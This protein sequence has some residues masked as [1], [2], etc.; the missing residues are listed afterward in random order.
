MKTYITLD[1][2]KQIASTKNVTLLT[3]LVVPLN[4][5][6]ER[7]EINTKLRV[8]HF[9]AQVLHESGSFI[10]FRELASGTA[11]EGRKDLG[12]VNPGD[13]VKYKGRGVIQITGRANYA[14]LSKDLGV[15]FVNQPLLLENHQWGVI[16]AG[17]FW[18]K[19]SL[20]KYADLDNVEKITR[21]VNG[22]LNGFDDRKKYLAKAKAAFTTITPGQ[23]ND[24]LA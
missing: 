16:S 14:S 24:L 8:C 15:D 23:N 12:N 20:N 21:M 5:C 1:Q 19:R 18:N 22:G 13:G 11:Y 2:L 6:L 3:E 7:Y 4:E 10:Y 9:L 17:W